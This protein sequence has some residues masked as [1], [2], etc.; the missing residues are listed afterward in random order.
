MKKL[1]PIAML[2]ALLVCL[3]FIGCPNTT[4]PEKPDT[5]PP[6][7]VTN[8]TVVPS[9]GQVTLT[10]TNSTDKDFEKIKIVYG[11]PAKTVEV[12]KTETTKVI[13]GLE[14][15]LCRSTSYK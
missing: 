9:D 4:A 13:T 5:T 12:P 14:I 11:D 6:A 7:Q 8:V 1:K 2:V 10:W 3:V 15:C